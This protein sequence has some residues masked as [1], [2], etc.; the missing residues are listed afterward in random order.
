MSFHTYVQVHEP[1]P[2]QHEW[3]C[4]GAIW[5]DEECLLVLW[6]STWLSSVEHH[7]LR[8]HGHM[9]WLEYARLEDQLLIAWEPTIERRLLQSRP[10]ALLINFAIETR[11]DRPGLIG[12]VAAKYLDVSLGEGSTRLAFLAYWKTT[13]MT[14]GQFIY[15]QA[16]H[17]S[18]RGHVVHK[19]QQ[20]VWIQ[21]EPTWVYYD[22]LD[23][24]KRDSLYPMRNDP[25]ALLA[26]FHRT[27][28]HYSTAVSVRKRLSN[29]PCI[30]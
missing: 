7:T 11:R 16:T 25:E 5:I 29:A 28:V 6:E 23:S 15:L 3:P 10:E 30:S 12:Y 20:K 21:W 27:I 24:K 14:K 13:P 22:H 17:S 26:R 9:G 2:Y 1:V 8:S 4:L 18:H 19:E